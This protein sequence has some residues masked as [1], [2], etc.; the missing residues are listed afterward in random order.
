MIYPSN[1]Q[2]KGMSLQKA[3]PKLFNSWRAMKSRCNNP[4]QWDYKYYGGQ[5]IKV[6]DD[7]KFFKDFI[8]WAL[9]NGYEEGLTI[10]RKDETKDYQPDNCQWLTHSENTAKAN[11]DRVLWRNKNTH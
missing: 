10:D 11:R 3:H 2:K 5:G 4:N 9:S 7:W 6:V 1:R 8:T